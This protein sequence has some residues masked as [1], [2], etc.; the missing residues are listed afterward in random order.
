MPASRNAYPTPA[1]EKGLDILELFAR[2][3]AGLTKSEVARRL[4][5]SVSEIFR[6]L[7]CLEDRGYIVREPEDDR[8]R[9]TLRLFHLAQEHPPTK[10]LLQ[11]AVP[12]LQD[13]AHRLGQSCH[14]GVLNDANV[15][16]TAVA[17]SPISPGFSVKLGSVVDLMQTASGHV[18]LS[19]LPPDARARAIEQWQTQTGGKPPRDF[20]THLRAIRT[21]GFEEH[22]SYVI[23]GVTNL[24]FPVLDER[25]VAIAAMTVPYLAR[26]EESVP[27]K[28]ARVVL[29]EA[30]DRLSR[31]L[32]CT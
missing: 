30:S 3:P 18:I 9:L 12:I 31:E 24:S 22:E 21:K 1:L 29:Q 6:M 26:M 32:G 20:E 15:V 7:V 17:E 19:Y 13:V 10:R 25:R 14:L 4:D 23:R 5:R 16:I 27:L 11:A 28:T 2:E 8:F